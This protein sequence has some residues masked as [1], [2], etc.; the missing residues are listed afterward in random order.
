MINYDTLLPQY[1]QQRLLLGINMTNENTK[2]GIS[3]LENNLSWGHQWSCG[4]SPFHIL[5]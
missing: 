5:G 2:A 4:D 3:K 1:Q